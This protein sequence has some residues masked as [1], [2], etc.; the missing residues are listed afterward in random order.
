MTY[1]ERALR[2]GE[3]Y[4]M[5][6]MDPPSFGRAGKGKVWDIHS[7][8]EPLINYLPRLVTEDC[9]GI[10]V[11]IHTQD[12]LADGIADL[13]NKVMPGRAVPLQMGTQTED[14]RVLEAGIAATWQNDS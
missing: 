14:G 8:L 3:R 7:D 1:V 4:H 11:S 5:V 12:M 10:W 9:R 6:I 2:K 13:V